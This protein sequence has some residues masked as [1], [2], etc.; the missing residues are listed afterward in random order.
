[1]NLVLSVK[2]KNEGD[3]PSPVLK[4]YIPFIFLI[5]MKL[6]KRSF[7]SILAF[8]LIFLKILGAYSVNITGLLSS[9]QKFSIPYSGC[10]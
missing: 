10:F 6:L 2:K 8:F 1:M 7:S 9:M 4:L 3:F 5:G